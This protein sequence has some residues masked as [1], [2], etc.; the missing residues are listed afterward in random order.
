[1]KIS[2]TIILLIFTTSV[3]AQKRKILKF[4]PISQVEFS[5]HLPVI[6]IIAKPMKNIKTNGIIEIKTSKKTYLLKDDG[7]MLQY[8]YEGELK[9]YP[10]TIIHEIEPNS[11]EYYFINRSTGSIDTLLSKPTFHPNKKKFICLEGLGTDIQQQ[12]QLSQ[13]VDGKILTKMYIQSKPYIPMSYVYWY[14]ENTIF[15]SDNNKKFY[16]ALVR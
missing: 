2:V 5:K 8:L 3:F 14:N 4:T 7:E 11:E 13:I 6:N 10:I 1:M 12:I 9:G 15:I 16:K